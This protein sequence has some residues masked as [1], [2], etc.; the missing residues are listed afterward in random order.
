MTAPTIVFDL[1]GTLVDTA[2]DLVDTL[3]LVLEREGLLPLHYASARNMIGGGARGLIERGVAA[4]GGQLDARRIDA[5]F[6]DF[7]KHYAMHIADRSRPFP[8][9]EAALDELAARG[10]RLAVC[11]NKL[12]W[13][14]VRL[15]D[16]LGLSERFA[17]VCGADTFGVRKPDGQM[18]RL[19]VERAGGRCDCAVMVGDSATDIATARAASVPFVAVDFGYTDVPIAKLNAD[20]VISH[21]AHLPDAA[22]RLLPATID[23]PSKHR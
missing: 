11:T 21:F 19:T 7:I 5:M 15:L 1:D 3:N 20:C 18:L 9:L 16:A 22:F 10:C 6:S 14:A 2:P 12:E 17:A 23:L 13:L 4:G 8:G